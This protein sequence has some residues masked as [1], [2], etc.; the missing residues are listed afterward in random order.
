M[1]L[2]K[3][4]WWE[5]AFAVAGIIFL[6]LGTKWVRSGALPEQ[7]IVL[8]AGGCHTPA[9]IL[10][11]R[12]TDEPPGTVILLHG[13]SANRRIM[14]YLASEFAGHGLQVYALDFPG[15]GDSEDSFSFAK[16]AEC[17]GAAVESLSRSGR[18]DPTK[19]ILVGHSMGGAIA[20]AMS[21]RL[22]VAATIAISPAPMILPKRMPSNLLVFSGEYELGVLHRAAASLFQAAGGNRA[23]PEDF[24]QKRAFD[25][26]YVAHAT[27]TSLITDRNVAHQS[28]RW[29]MQTLFPDIPPETLALNLDLAPYATANRGRHRLAG[30]VLGL[31]GIL[32]LFPFCATL[33]TSLSGRPRAESDGTRPPYALSLVEVAVAALAGV[34]LLILGDPLKFLHMYT[35]DYL[36]SLLLIV[37][38]VLL[39]L[40][41]SY[42]RAVWPPNVSSFAVAAILGFA[43]FLAVGGWLNWQLDDAW[44]NAPRRLRFF[45]ILPIAYVFCSAEELV[46]GPVHSGR[47]RALRFGVFVLLRLEIF[48]ACTLAY[49]KL[50]SG[51][52]LIPLLFVFLAA[53]SILQRL[54]ADGVRARSGSA[55]AAILFSAI[56]AAWFV[57]SVF[58]LT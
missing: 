38:I 47:R 49:Y 15:H 28:E 27:H 35:A 18:I 46:L 30:A 56:L 43:V 31:I 4:K 10:N 7:R 13:L 23:S 52:V 3:P 54:A 1:N 51:Q 2:S 19:T 22:P 39:I 50:M 34:L 20:I 40:N 21:D 42:I 11:P 9:T 16:A 6:I 25:L 17:A 41:R 58:P 44:L 24:A 57:A 37:G 12:I 55:T 36:L 32:F 33:I 26:R 45:G 48:L 29:I 53:F 14:M 8:D 5:S